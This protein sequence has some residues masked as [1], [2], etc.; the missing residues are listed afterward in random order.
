M[1]PARQSHRDALLKAAKR[2]LRE[3]QYGAISARDLVASWEKANHA[4]PDSV[5]LLRSITGSRSDLART[6]VGLRVVRGL[7]PSVG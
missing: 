4:V 7:L 1:S 6:S 3:R 2:L 5:R